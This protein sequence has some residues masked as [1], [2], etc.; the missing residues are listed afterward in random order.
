MEVTDSPPKTFA[1]RLH[2]GRACAP[3]R[4]MDV[5]G[6]PPAP[7]APL[8][9]GPEAEAS[10]EDEDEGDAAAADVGGGEASATEHDDLGIA[11][12]F[13]QVRPKLGD[14]CHTLGHRH[15]TNRHRH[16]HLT[17]SYP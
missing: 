9:T 1:P 5:F 17:C 7:E 8:G 4:L 14:T 3:L 15:P 16:P 13:L 2:H 6:I 11:P 12:F 10:D